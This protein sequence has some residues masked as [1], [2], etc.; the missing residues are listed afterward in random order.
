MTT[1]MSKISRKPI[2]LVLD[3]FIDTNRI[4]MIKQRQFYGFSITEA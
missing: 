3:I 2:L 1:K 4:F